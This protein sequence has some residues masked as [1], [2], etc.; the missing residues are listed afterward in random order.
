MIRKR[1]RERKD[2]P[3]N[4]GPGYT[5]MSEKGEDRRNYFQ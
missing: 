2:H 5:I 1:K 3:R 4:R